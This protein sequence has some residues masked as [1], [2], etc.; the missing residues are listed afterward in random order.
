MM[1]HH[2]QKQL[3]EERVCFVCSSIDQVIIESSEDRN[4]SRAG[5]WR[6]S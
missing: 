1:E 2:D 3:V 6:Q 5:T 4:S